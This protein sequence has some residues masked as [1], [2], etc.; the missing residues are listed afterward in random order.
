METLETEIKK[1]A[2]GLPYWSKYLAQKIL[3]SNAIY[4]KDID[5]SYSYLLEELGL[6]PTTIKSEIVISN[7]YE[8]SGNYKQDLFFSKLENIEGVNALA[9]NQIIE[10]SQHL[11]IIYGVN[12][13][14]KS[15]YVRL[16][17]KAFYSKAPEEILPNIHI[18]DGHKSITAK[19]TFN[20]NGTDIPL[21]YP[22]NEHSIEFKQFSVFDGKSVLKHLEE[23]NEFAFRPPGL[24]FFADYTNAIN[25]VE[26]KLKSDIIAK[27][28]G[29][30]ASDLADLFD[31]D[32]E[33][34]TLVKNLSAST[35]IEDLNK[36]TPFLE[37]DKVEKEKI[38]KQYD[39]ILLASKGKEQEIKNL[40]NIKKLLE[41][42]KKAI[43]NINQ[44]FTTEYLTKIK[45][46]ITDCLNKEATAK[47]EGIEKFKTNKIEGIGTKEWKNFILAAE[48][49][50]KNQKTKNTGY[51]DKG[52]NC[53]LCHQPLTEDAEKLIT[54]YWVFIKSVAEENARNAQN[55]LNKEKQVLEKLNF[56]LFPDNNT[57]TVWLA[58]KYPNQ[59]N[60]INKILSVQKTLAE[61]TISDI[62]NKAAN[63]RAEIIASVAE[64]AVIG[65]AIDAT[66]KG[67]RDDEQSQE[68]ERLQKTK[69]YLEHKE[70]F[71]SHFSK[72]E[73]YIN[74]QVWINKASNADFA[75]RKITETEKS[76]SD[77][78]FNQRYIEAFNQECDRLN[79]SFGIKIN[80]TGSAGKSYRQ[81]KL[82]DN[83]PNAI[84]SE[85]EQ[86]IIALADFIAE[87]QLSEVNKGIILDDP[88]TS[89]DEKRK[90]EIA[91]R[92]V[93][94]SNSKQVII[95]THDLVFVSSLIGH[96]KDSNINYEC[97]WIE[98]NGSQPG[99]VWLKNTPAVEESYYKKCKAQTY[100]D[101][102]LKLSPESREDKIKNGFAALRTSYEALVIFGLFNGVVRRF[103]EIVRMT[104]L[105]KVSFSDQI[106]D[107]ILDSFAHCC[108][109]MEGHSHSDKYANKKPTVD[110]L[111][112]EVDRFIS[113]KNKISKKDK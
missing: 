113:I 11:T 48:T 52:D 53:L 37:E 61:N 76:L 47:A 49:F 21:G 44:Y 43:E 75:K 112:E 86:K 102:A 59:L 30:T 8:S 35:K 26:Q 36:Y 87:M 5:T 81:L 97:H 82:K 16:L 100:Y 80:H 103:D 34:K 65:N 98:N 58:E 94:E 56:D 92:L 3:L 78:Y 7:T 104:L 9:E 27:N 107:E 106:R 109:Y 60:A 88:V 1:L 45:N 77:K 24:A 29:N 39:D 108:R 95:F 57:L 6:N 66:I 63:A 85:G 20:S 10:F 73:T 101:D 15:G 28:T 62:Q 50:A 25:S 17:K 105:E 42:N 32:S 13:S 51:P 19:L 71:N 93:E 111:K 70:K 46:T 14:G 2:N 23:K 64:Y 89:L 55:E 72:F 4:E 40:E 41:E 90:S 99:L 84:L 83:K 96:C 110:N 79:G 74:N 69:I 54:N 68:L 22:I 18:N 31:G 38:Q 91:K 33:I 67:F 12:G